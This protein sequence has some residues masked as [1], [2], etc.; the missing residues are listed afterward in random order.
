MDVINTK[1]VSEQ[2]FW[3]KQRTF[4]FLSSLVTMIDAQLLLDPKWE[5]ICATN[6]TKSAMYP[7]MNVRQTMT[8]RTKVKENMFAL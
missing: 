4:A 2:V 6:I 1:C 5:L 7:L 3:V 8:V